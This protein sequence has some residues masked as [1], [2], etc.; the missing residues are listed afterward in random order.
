M[1]IEESS[2]ETLEKA[3]ANPLLPQ[4]NPVFQKPEKYFQRSQL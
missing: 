3:E 2:A 4:L 1:W